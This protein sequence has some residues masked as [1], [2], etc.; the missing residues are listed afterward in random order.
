MNKSDF[1]EIQKTFEHL[2]T[3]HEKGFIPFL[4][5]GDPNEQTFLKII[6]AISPYTDIIELGIP[7]SDPLADGPTIQKANQRALA[8]DITLQKSFNL[9]K[10]VKSISSKPIVLLTYANI[11]GL[12]SEMVET[13]S[14]FI[15]GGVNGIIIADVPVEEIEMYY[16]KFQELGLNNIMLVTPTTKND[17]LKS[18]LKYA[19]GFLYLV[20]VKGVTGA[21]ETILDETK[22]TIKFISSHI[23]GKDGYKIP[24]CVGFGISTPD[25]VRELKTQNIDG[26]IVGSAIIKIIENNLDNEE[27]MLK[28]L[29]IYVKS[30]KEATL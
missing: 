5:I 26:V 14:K 21:R 24:I 29:G 13:L 7:F 22:Q 20:S 15:E 2:R 27:E 25:H 30:M 8:Q 9:I 3:K 6:E 17:R 23:D 10:K 1:N 28:K 11:V 12:D 4:T 16:A 18:I 19:S